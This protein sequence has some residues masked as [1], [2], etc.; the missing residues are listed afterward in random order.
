MLLRCNPR[1][2]T[3]QLVRIAG[4]QQ[5]ARIVLDLP[6]PLSRDRKRAGDPLFERRE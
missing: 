4:K 5:L 2:L 6:H 1:S 3:L